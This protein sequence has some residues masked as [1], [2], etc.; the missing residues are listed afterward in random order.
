MKEVTNKRTSSSSFLAMLASVFIIIGGIF[1]FNNY[2]QSKKIVAYDYMANI[3][4]EKATKE[5]KKIEKKEEQKKEEQPQQQPQEQ[6]VQETPAPV[7]QIS[8]IGYLEIPKI[9]LKKGFLDVN[10]KDNDVEKNIYVAPNSSYPDVSKGNLIIAAH[11]GTG[12]KAFF[13]DLYKLEKGDSLY[14]TYKSKKYIYKIDNIYKQNKS[15]KISI[16]RDYEKTTLTLVTCTNNDSK[17]QTVYIA[18]LVETQDI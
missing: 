18:Y 9:N 3:F 16:Y 15:G 2:I 5:A 6:P 4:Y 1:V 10:D 11:S 12:W 14:I 17:T 13:N 8:Y 7:Y